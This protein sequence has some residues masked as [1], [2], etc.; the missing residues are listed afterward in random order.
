MRVSVDARSEPSGSEIEA[1]QRTDIRF[2]H[3]EFQKHYE[4]MLYCRG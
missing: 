2:R 1:Y 3:K 4:K